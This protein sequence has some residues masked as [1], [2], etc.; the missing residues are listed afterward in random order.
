MGKTVVVHIKGTSDSNFRVW[1]LDNDEVTSSRQI[2]MS[3][4]FRFESG[5]YDYLIELTT[6]YFDAE[7]A[8]DTAR[9]LAFKA[10]TWDTTLDNFTVN[11]I[12]V[13]Y[14]TLD[15]YMAGAE[16]N[17]EYAAEPV[18]E[19]GTSEDEAASGDDAETSDGEA[20]DE[21]ASDG[22]AA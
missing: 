7:I 20:A 15:D 14:G 21:Q 12:G 6:E 10:L 2:N 13:Y 9:Q 16:S 8:D 18:V 4:Y 17:P 19:A 11:E 5:E 22:E 1:L 3:D